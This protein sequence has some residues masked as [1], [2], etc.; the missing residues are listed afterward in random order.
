[1]DLEAPTHAPMPMTEAPGVTPEGGATVDLAPG[2][3]PAAPRRGTI[4]PTRVGGAKTTVEAGAGATMRPGATRVIA[5]AAG[6]AHARAAAA[7]AEA[8]RPA[9]AGDGPRAD[10]GRRRRLPRVEEPAGA[11]APVAQ[12]T[13]VPTPPPTTLATPAPP[14]V[15]AAPAPEFGEAGG[16]AAASV[17]VAQ[18]AFESGNYDKAVASAQAALREDDASEPAKKIL[19]QAM[20]GQKSADQV[21]TGDAALGRG[22]LAAAEAAAAEAYRIAPW[23]DRAVGAAAPHRRGEGQGAARRRRPRRRPPAPRR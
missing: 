22:D 9:V 6:S 12:A 4:A 5:G 8:E 18:A 15:T 10:R 13:P 1:M 19:A 7:A 21:R 11:A 3:R 23:N 14:P 17:K 16:K 2:R 20:V